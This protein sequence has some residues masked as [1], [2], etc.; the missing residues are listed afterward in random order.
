[1][2]KYHHRLA[3]DYPHAC[4]PAEIR[5]PIRIDG[6]HWE[7]LEDWLDGL[8]MKGPEISTST[9]Y[10]DCARWEFYPNE[11]LDN[12]GRI[13]RPDSLAGLWVKH[14]AGCARG[15]VLTSILV[16]PDGLAELPALHPEKAGEWLDKIVKFWW[17]GLQQPLPVTAKTALAYLKLLFLSDGEGVLEKARE[18]ARKAY[19]G[20][21]YH[22]EGELGY[23]DGV[24]LK[25]CYPD[26][27]TL[28][29][30]EQ[31]HFKTLAKRNYG[32]LMATIQTDTIHGQLS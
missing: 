14:L 3:E 5:F 21:G 1:M 2:L 13:S 23:G 27:D 16:A 4:P 11:I 19:E 28:W 17:Q 12:K 24:Y 9:K 15:M 18:A 10:T 29:Q 31:C 25:R 30:A 32:P 7:V 6:C 8:R 20:D 26:F 22:F